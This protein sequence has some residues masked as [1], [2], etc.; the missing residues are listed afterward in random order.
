MQRVARTIEFLRGTYI[1]ALD[2]EAAADLSN[3][4]AEVIGDSSYRQTAEQLRA[5]YEAIMDTGEVDM[6]EDPLD[7]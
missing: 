6:T 3:S 1:E 2:F 7:N 5:L 4:I